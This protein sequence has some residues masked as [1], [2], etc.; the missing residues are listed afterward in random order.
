M[1]SV[2]GS[3]LVGYLTGTERVED[4]QGMEAGEVCLI[5]VVHFRICLMHV[6]NSRISLIHIAHSRQCHGMV[7]EEKFWGQSHGTVSRNCW[8]NNGMGS[9]GRTGRHFR[10]PRRAQ[11]PGRG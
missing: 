4:Q 10:M 11:R 5:Q 6:V 1:A 2:Q 8:T 9:L 3:S 7:Y